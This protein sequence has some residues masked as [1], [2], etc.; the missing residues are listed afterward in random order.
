MNKY[1][2]KFEPGI[3]N[4]T[5]HSLR[6]FHQRVYVFFFRERVYVVGCNSKLIESTYE[7]T[8]KSDQQHF[9]CAILSSSPLKINV[10]SF[11]LFTYL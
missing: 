4:I 11:K 8:I 7:A 10:F 5:M 3:I 6:I 9:L 2:P 1:N